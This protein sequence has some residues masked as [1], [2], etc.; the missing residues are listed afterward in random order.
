MLIEKELSKQQFVFKTLLE[1]VEGITGDRD[2]A[3][4]WAITPNK[5]L[6]GFSPMKL[7]YL[8][9]F[10]K[11]RELINTYPDRAGLQ[12]LLGLEVAKQVV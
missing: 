3:W 2:R 7:A 9:Q 1:Q 4:I 8:Q 10:R 5:A 11:I 12:E 6:G